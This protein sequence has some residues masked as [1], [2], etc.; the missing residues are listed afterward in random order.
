MVES[1]GVDVVSSKFKSA[2]VGSTATTIF[3]EM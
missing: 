1:G 2:R 3:A